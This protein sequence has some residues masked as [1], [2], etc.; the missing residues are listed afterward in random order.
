MM[1][2]YQRSLFTQLLDLNYELS[3][4]DYSDTV[5]QALII[6]M[7]RVEIDL[8]NDMGVQEWREFKEK[9]KRMFS[10]A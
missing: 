8:E 1:T 5:Q 3:V 2:P 7:S 4:G 9:G 6:A 10:P